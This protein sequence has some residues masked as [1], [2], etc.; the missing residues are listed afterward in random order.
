MI[1]DCLQTKI[2]MLLTHV[3]TDNKD[4]TRIEGAQGASH[5]RVQRQ[6]FSFATTYALSMRHA[7]AL[8]N[9]VT[10]NKCERT[11]WLNTLVVATPCASS[12]LDSGMALSKVTISSSV[13]TDLARS[14]VF[15]RGCS[16]SLRSLDAT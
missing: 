12:R 3:P 7:S 5:A 8:D 1:S 15:A 2:E 9:V 10:T 16:A 6:A 13:H 14:P 4:E 11:K